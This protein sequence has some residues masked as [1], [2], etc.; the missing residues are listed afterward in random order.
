MIV[1]FPHMGKVYIPAKGLFDDLGAVSY[2]HLDVYK[3]QLLSR[4]R[5]SIRATSI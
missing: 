2:T 1:T 4:P 5:K 3:R